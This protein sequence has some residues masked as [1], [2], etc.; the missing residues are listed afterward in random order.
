MRLVDDVHT[1]RLEALTELTDAL[2]TIGLYARGFLADLRDTHWADDAS[3]LHGAAE[4]A[5][6]AACKLSFWSQCE[7]QDSGDTLT[8]GDRPARQQSADVKDE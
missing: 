7:D 2:D 3:A 8:R 6:M 5:I 4:R 1:S